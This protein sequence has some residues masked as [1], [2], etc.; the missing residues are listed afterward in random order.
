MKN[1]TII[2][3]IL[4]I[5]IIVFLIYGC[6]FNNN[7]SIF[8]EGA[9][10]TSIPDNFLA[11]I[12]GYIDARIS[13]DNPT[14]TL[15]DETIIRNIQLLGINNAEIL[16][17]L[18]TMSSYEDGVNQFSSIVG[19]G[20]YNPLL[21]GLVI[22]YNFDILQT[23]N[24]IKNKSINNL[25]SRPSNYDATI[26]L[27]N[28]SATTILNKDQ[29]I[30]NTNCLY[31]DGASKSYLSIPRFPDCYNGTG[32]LGMTISVWFKADRSNMTGRCP[33]VFDF[34]NGPGNDNILF[35]VNDIGSGKYGNCFAAIFSNNNSMS[36]SDPVTQFVCDNKWKHL[37]WTISSAAGIHSLYINNRLISNNK[38]FFPTNIGRSKNYIG[39]SLWDWDDF[40]KGYIDDFRVYQ[41]E[42]N[43]SDVSALFAL[44]TKM[45]PFSFTE[46][47]ESIIGSSTIIT[48]Y[49]GNVTVTGNVPKISFNTYNGTWIWEG[50]P[51][52]SVF[53]L[54][55]GQSES[56]YWL[57]NRDNSLESA[58]ARMLF[59]QC[60]HSPKT[61]RV[62]TSLY[63]PKTDNYTLRFAYI[64]STRTPGA[65]N[66][67]YM[68]N[69]ITL[70]VTLGDSYIIF[71]STGQKYT[72]SGKISLSI[73]SNDG[74]VSTAML[75]NPG[76]KNPRNLI[77]ITLNFFGIPIGNRFLEFS[78]NNSLG[79]GY[80]VS[81]ISLVPSPAGSFC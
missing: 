33:R 31:L 30:V 60:Y 73:K 21:D 56:N 68:N 63:I 20:I 15:S 61:F 32:F 51:G 70:K 2:F 18:K 7:C 1:K 6:V 46:D 11:I 19:A 65:P 3:G 67:A 81:D 45:P 72:T 71:N 59:I 23:G 27:N 12:S 28:Q 75:N 17:I 80:A 14:G 54:T 36:F 26:I 74:S 69:N 55:K 38:S 79:D 24:I 48:R 35:S 16:N 57:S 76:F 41:R 62:Y 4:A 29:S 10:G 77:Y 34:A 58:T 25:P 42:L 50:E 78:N 37:V 49:S 8:R 39:K 44:G 22:H 43:P 5:L 47:F 9:T 13:P 40:F 53:T 66:Q 52:Y 64:N